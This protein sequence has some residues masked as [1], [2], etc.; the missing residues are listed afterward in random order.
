MSGKDTND[1]AL[2]ELEVLIEEFRQS[3][4]RELHARCG[5]LEVYLSQDSDASG[6]DAPR[7]SVA[8]PA[9]H[10]VP[11]ATASS[12]APVSAAPSS[13]PAAPE[14]SVLVTAP[15]LG[16]FYRAPKPG[17]PAYVEIGGSVSTESE[18][19]L[20]EVMK[21][22]TAVRAG[23]AGKVVQVLASDGDLVSAGQP[24]FAIQPE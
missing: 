13:A 19:C 20:V 12:A 10:A 1:P 18:V 11:V 5:D 15:Y 17:A 22:F 2:P 21:L 6:L 8:A 7:V 14:G 4:L 24:L 3:G 16:T 23:V 9:A